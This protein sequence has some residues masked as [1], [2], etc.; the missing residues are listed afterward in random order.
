MDQE[1]PCQEARPQLAKS[2]PEAKTEDHK[3]VRKAV[4]D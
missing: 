3:E 2:L 4:L 1:N